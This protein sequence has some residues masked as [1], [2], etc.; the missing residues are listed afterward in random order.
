M[1]PNL[2]RP[3]NHPGRRKSQGPT[4]LLRGRW[5]IV[6]KLVINDDPKLALRGD[7]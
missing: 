6:S 1:L 4:A 3:D 7:V 2:R 5:K